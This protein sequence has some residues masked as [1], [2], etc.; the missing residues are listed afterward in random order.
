M[1]EDWIQTGRGGE[2]TSVKNIIVICKT[3]NL[4]KNIILWAQ[5]TLQYKE[6]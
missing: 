5:P 3:K 4:P 1:N 6:S 2:N